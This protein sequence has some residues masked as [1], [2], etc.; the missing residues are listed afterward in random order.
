MSTL[1]SLS[2]LS[3]S[4]RAERVCIDNGTGTDPG[5]VAGAGG[6]GGSRKG[7]V[8]L[9][10]QIRSHGNDGTGGGIQESSAS[11]YGRKRAAGSKERDGEGGEGGKEYDERFE[12]AAAGAH[13]NAECE[14]SYRRRS[15]T[16]G[17]AVAFGAHSLHD[18][19]NNDES[20]AGAAEHAAAEHGGGIGEVAPT[21]ED[22]AATLQAAARGMIARKSFS[23]VRKQ[24]MASLVIQKSLV[25]WF[26]HSKSSATDDAPF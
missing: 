4:N 24:T 5:A 13:S 21:A 15:D 20:A 19:D 9:R 16:T 10:G 8:L 6:A 3:I 14:R 22:A 12:T 1:S 7:V 2:S 23:S 18:D 26:V 17:K 25:K 11:I